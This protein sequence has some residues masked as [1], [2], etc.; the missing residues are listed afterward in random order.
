MAIKPIDIKAG[1][2]VFKSAGLQGPISGPPTVVDSDENGKLIRV[3]PFHYDEYVD[4]DKKNP[5]KIEERGSVFKPPKRTVHGAF[6][7]GYKKRVYSANRVKWPLKRVYWDP[8][9][10][11]NPQTRGK[12]GYVRISLWEG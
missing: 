11:R 1:K 5:W 6:Y 7:L 10:E 4:W 8:N 3:R 9:G 12:S 2:R